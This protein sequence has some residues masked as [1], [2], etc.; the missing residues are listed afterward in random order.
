M[1]DGFAHHRKVVLEQDQI[2]SCTGDIRGTIDRN[3]NIRGVQRRGIIDAIA[4]EAD[5]I[6]EPL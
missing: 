1:N 2:G 3:P 6:T 5:D 4:H